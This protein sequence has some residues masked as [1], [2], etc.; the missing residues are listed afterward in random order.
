MIS[1]SFFSFA[2]EEIEPMP[3][4]YLNVNF[5]Q[6]AQQYSNFIAGEMN[7]DCLVS[8]NFSK[9]IVAWYMSCN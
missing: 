5:V 7:I 9:K 1:L 4:L 2:A 6:F 3:I 8:S